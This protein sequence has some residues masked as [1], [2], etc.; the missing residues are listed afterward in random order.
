MQINKHVWI[1]W[2]RQTRNRSMAKAL[3]AEYLEYA[4]KKGML[5]YVVLSSKTLFFLIKRK[6][7]IV[8]FQNPSIVLGLVCAIYG[9]FFRRGKL[10]G[11]YHNCALNKSSPLF[12]VNKFIARHCSLVIVTNPSLE[13]IVADMGGVAVSFPDP[14]PD[15]ERFENEHLQKTKDIV[16]VTSWAND[17]PINEV[18]NAFI[19][20]GLAK[21]EISLLMTGRPKFERLEHSQNYYEQRGIK[22]LGFVDESY[23]WSILKNSYFVIDLTTRD[24][25]MVCGAYEALAVRRVLLLSENEA[26]VNYFGKNVIYTNNTVDDIKQKLLFIS[27]NISLLSDQVSE[28]VFSVLEKQNNN[29][30]NIESL[31]K[32]YNQVKY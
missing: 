7:E 16:F 17:E 28:T 29:I 32:A 10:V 1:T 23:Y 18:L 11:D 22:F 19:V 20:S 4:Y 3:R 2:E 15:V 25:C 24:N 14:L 8:Y 9:L 5:R 30:E 6:P 27:R 21:D 26:S 13:S 12:F 31:L